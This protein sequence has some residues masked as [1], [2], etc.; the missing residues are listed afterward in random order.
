MLKRVRRG[1]ATQLAE[2]QCW[3]SIWFHIDVPPLTLPAC[4]Q[5]SHA[6]APA[7]NEPVTGNE[8]EG[9]PRSV[10]PAAGLT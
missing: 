9:P 2:I 3:L 1:V 5:E 4:W 7:G 10:A 6:S 8:L